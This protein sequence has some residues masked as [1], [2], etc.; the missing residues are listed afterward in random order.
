MQPQF[1]ISAEAAKRHEYFQDLP[2]RIHDLA[3][4]NRNFLLWFY[5]VSLFIYLLLYKLEALEINKN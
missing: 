3:D 5:C 4:G 1:R 2:P